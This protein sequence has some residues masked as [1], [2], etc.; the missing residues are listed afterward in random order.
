LGDDFPARHGRSRGWRAEDGRWQMANG[1]VGA[2]VCG[3]GFA[4]AAQTLRES[5]RE[6]GRWQMANGKVGAG[7]C[8]GESGQAAQALRESRREDGR[9]QMANGK[10]G[11]RVCGGGFAQAAQALRDGVTPGWIF[12]IRRAGAAACWRLTPF[13]PHKPAICRRSGVSAQRAPE[14]RDRRSVRR[15]E[16]SARASDHSL[17][18]FRPWGIGWRVW[19]PPWRPVC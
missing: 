9:W 19:L 12:H 13:Q 17:H 16:R 5:R 8:G 11:P 10:V 18:R 14:L 1:K 7:V 15:R 4:Q 2:G 6:D 3:E